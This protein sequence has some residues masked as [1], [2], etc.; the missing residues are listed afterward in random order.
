MLICIAQL[1]FNTSKLVEFRAKQMPKPDLILLHAPSVYNFRERPTMFGPISDVIPSTPVFEMYPL[2]FVSILGFLEQNGFHVRIINLAV[3]MLKN[4]RLDVD[5]LISRLDA[6]AFGFDL[7]WLV[8][9]AGSLDLAKIVKK[10][11]PGKPVILGGLS[12]SYYHE[13]IIDNFQQI[14]YI[15]RGD[16]IEKPLLSLM[17]C[18][19]KST[20]P[21]DV[22]NLTWRKPDGKKR[23]NPLSYVPYEIDDLFIDYGQVVKLVLRHL[24]LESALPYENFMEYPFTA[25]LTCKGCKYDCVTCG[26][27]N[28]SFRRFFN[29]EKPVFKT[30]DKLVEE[31]RIVSEYFKAPLFLIGDLRQAGM[32][33]AEDV[34]D[35]IKA[36]FFDNTITFELFDAVPKDYMNKISESADSWTLEISP[37]SH[38]DRVR[39]ALGKPYTTG[40]MEKTIKRG[41]DHGCGKI[42]V[43]FMVG[44]P[45]QTVEST[46]G[47]VEYSKRLYEEMGGDERIFTFIAPMAPF[48]DPGSQIFE[49]P[50][51]YGYRLFYR[52]F[53]EHKQALSEPCWN[54]YLSYETNLMSR[55]EIA[56][57][58]YESMIKMNEL[59]HEMGITETGDYKQI[60]FGL[61]LSRDIMGKI[62]DIRASVKEER[63][64]KKLYHSLRSEI[65]DAEKSAGFAKKYLRMPGMAGIRVKGAVKHLLR[66]VNLLK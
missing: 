65:E 2:G 62:N 28:Y 39:E 57:T 4:P 8:H 51:K 22:E 42:D 52:S 59:K 34:L 58:T 20:L 10:H 43:Y 30:P 32:R 44:L 23:I 9:A 5:R 31:M 13:E 55:N 18:V 47:S 19:E 66:S 26:G 3:K 29:R 38:E 11:H 16:T 48:L 61:E 41:L 17:E 1:T 64:R 49:S 50:G 54:L 40:E 7:H 6:K 12:S 56:G 15:L 24:D 53:K 21:S 45:G 37:E 36:E 14:D 27:S 33:W 35:N 60:E 25:L 63:A 46:L